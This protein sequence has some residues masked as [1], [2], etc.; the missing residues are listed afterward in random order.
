MIKIYGKPN[1]PFC[2]KAKSLAELK[3]LDYVYLTLGVDYTREELINLVPNAR[4]VPQ[5]F[6]NETLIG[7]YDDFETFVK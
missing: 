1:C 4:S 7:G 5:V 6:V 3:N 2:V